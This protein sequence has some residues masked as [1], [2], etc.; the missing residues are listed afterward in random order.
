MKDVL[1]NSDESS[2]L[3]QSRSSRPIRPH[4]GLDRSSDFHKSRPIKPRECFDQLDT[5]ST[6][7]YVMSM[8]AKPSTKQR[9]RTLDSKLRV[10]GQ[11]KRW[12]VRRWGQDGDQ[13]K[14]WSDTTTRAL[15]WRRHQHCRAVASEHAV[16]E[17]RSTLRHRFNS[18]K[19]QW[20]L[21]QN[22]NTLF[23]GSSQ[24]KLGSSFSLAGGTLNLWWSCAPPTLVGTLSTESELFHRENKIPQGKLPSDAFEPSEYRVKF[25]DW[26]TNPA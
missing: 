20:N 24:M 15:C 7:W 6:F 4:E 1:P 2:T 5:A 14:A 26:C 9:K 3:N 10:V 17:G 22:V 8:E 16:L 11:S 12:G 25:R 13:E 18:E 23:Y 21:F 19:I